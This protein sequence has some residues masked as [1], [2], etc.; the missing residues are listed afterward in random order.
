MS[1]ELSRV[2]SRQKQ[3]KSESKH[4]GKSKK[5]SGLRRL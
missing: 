4:P 3:H 1:E 2:K 5:R